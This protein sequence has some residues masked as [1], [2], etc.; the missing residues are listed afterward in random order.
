MRLTLKFFSQTFCAG[1]SPSAYVI[2]VNSKA[3]NDWLVELSMFSR[4]VS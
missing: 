3:E 1:Q 4:G 2:E